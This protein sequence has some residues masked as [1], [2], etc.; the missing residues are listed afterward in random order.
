MTADGKV[1]WWTSKGAAWV[2]LDRAVRNGWGTTLR[3]ALLLVVIIVGG[4]LAGA[5]AGDATGWILGQLLGPD[6]AAAL[7]PEGAGS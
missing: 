6:V 4:H 5:A 1:Q 2:V 7:P 3:L